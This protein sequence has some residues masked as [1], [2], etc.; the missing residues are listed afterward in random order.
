MN[1]TELRLFFLTVVE[2]EART[3]HCCKTVAPTVED[4]TAQATAFYGPCELNAWSSRRI[5]TD[6][7]ITGGGTFIPSSYDAHLT[8]QELNAISD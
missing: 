2:Y 1:S 5:H 6:S 8:I 7:W 4:A 3:I